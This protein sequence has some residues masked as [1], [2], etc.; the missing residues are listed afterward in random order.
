M[1]SKVSNLGV[2]LFFFCVPSL[3]S[4]YFPK[5]SG[6]PLRAVSVS[7]GNP[8]PESLMSFSPTGKRLWGK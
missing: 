2:K 4:G 7:V 8:H 5:L 6:R 3:I 1:S